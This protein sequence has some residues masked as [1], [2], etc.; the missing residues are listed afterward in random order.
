MT[1]QSTAIK[2]LSEALRIPVST[3]MPEHDKP[4]KF[5]LVSRI[6]GGA[7]DWATRNPRFLIECYAHSEYAAEE[8][9]ELVWETWHTMRSTMFQ[10]CRSDNNLT[11]YADPDSKLF[12]FQFTGSMQLRAR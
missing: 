9:G 12:R 7:N 8:L 10:R 5:V 6:G 11:Q 4:D 2:A 3:R 1:A